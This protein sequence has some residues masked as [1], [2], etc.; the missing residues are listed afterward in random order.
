MRHDF[1]CVKETQFAEGEH[2]GPVLE[3]FLSRVVNANITINPLISCQSSAEGDDYPK[4]S[5]ERRVGTECRN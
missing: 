3:P 1:D 2:Y 4:R 5:E